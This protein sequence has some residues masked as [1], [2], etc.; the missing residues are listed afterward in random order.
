ME[1]RAT[2]VTLELVEIGNPGNLAD[3]TPNGQY[4][5]VPH[6]FRLSRNETTVGQYVAFLNAVARFTTDAQGLVQPYLEQLWAAD[7]GKNKQLAAQIKRTGDARSGYSYAAA[8]NDVADQPIANVSWYSAARFA[9]W[10]HNGQP[11]ASAITANPGTETGAY[12]LNQTTTAIVSKNPGAKYWVPSEDEWYKAAYFDPI[13]GKKGGY[14]SF[15]TRAN[16]TPY[17]GYPPDFNQDNAAN[18]NAITT[19]SKLN[20]VGSF[21]RSG[22]SYGIFDQAGSL[23][24]WTD[25]V[26]NNAQGQPNSLITRGGSWSLGILNPG[27]LVRRDYTPDEVDDDIGFR[28]ASSKPATVKAVRSKAKT[29]PTEPYSSYQAPASGRNSDSFQPTAFNGKAAQQRIA[30]VQV[31]DA[32]NPADAYG[33]GS[34]PYVFRIGQHEITTAQYAVFLNSVA[35]SSQAAQ[36]IQDLWQPEMQDSTE[37]PGVLI[38]RNRTADG[39]WSF[40]VPAGREELPIGWTNWFAAARFTNWMHNGATREAS[41]ETG[42]YSLN[43][44]STGVFI[45]EAG[46]RFWI[47]SEDEWVKAAYFDPAKSTNK[48]GK[49]TADYWAYATQSDVLPED[50]VTG[51]AFSSN[52]A[53][54]YNDQRN[55]GD[56]FTPVGSYRNAPSHYGAF[57]M[58]GNVWEWNDAII[59]SPAP[60]SGQ[61][62][63]RGVRGGSFSQGI[64]AINS[65]TRRDYPTGYRAPDGYLFYSDDDTGFRIAS[66]MD[67]TLNPGVTAPA[68]ASLLT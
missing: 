27:K 67:L 20:P 18:Y 23:W 59:H 66:A 25:K 29:S 49:A 68:S 44:A 33:Y 65:S 15:P 32:G 9:N 63:S 48:K 28:L 62:D 51:N 57:D 8:S 26:I 45:R 31:G 41:T 58:T 42:A 14:W 6:S 47:P 46:A 60:L 35:T 10:M 1:D 55:K 24:E 54:N 61:P 22:S 30:M 56:V 50:R 5:A 64:L 36:V 7:M 17:N 43:G 40:A 4:G 16:T 19:S 38:T 2:K 3:P 53:A 34:V 11:T 12:T 37:K 13:K 39:N 52:N 21:K